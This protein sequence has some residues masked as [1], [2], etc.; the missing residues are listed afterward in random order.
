VND[1]LDVIGR[2]SPAHDAD[3]VVLIPAD[4]VGESVGFSSA[5]TPE[6]VPVVWRTL[7]NRQRL[8]GHRQ[9][10]SWHTQ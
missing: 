4:Q 3:H 1:L 8:I 10:Y 5:D 6:E 7:L 2:H 9:V